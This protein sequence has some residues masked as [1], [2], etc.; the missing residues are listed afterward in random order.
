M[1]VIVIIGYI[2][3]SLVVSGC[4]SATSRNNL[5]D[6]EADTLSA[7]QRVQLTTAIQVTQSLLN[8]NNKKIGN[9]IR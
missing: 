3:L 8:I 2:I 1:K 4:S 9:S 7:S 6:N 5:A